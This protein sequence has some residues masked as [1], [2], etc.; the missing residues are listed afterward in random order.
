MSTTT[1]ITI[2]ANRRLVVLFKNVEPG[3]PNS[4]G[5]IV[6][7]ATAYEQDGDRVLVHDEHGVFHVFEGVRAAV[8]LETALLR[9]PDG[10][11]YQPDVVIEPAN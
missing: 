3:S 10:R 4:P 5:S 11:F 6:D 1:K 8:V 2:P 7:K 9:S